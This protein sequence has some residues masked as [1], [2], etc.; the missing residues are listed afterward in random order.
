MSRQN[1]PIQSSPE[2][3]SLAEKRE[4]EK[5]RQSRLKFNLGYSLFAITAAFC[6]TGVGLFWSGK[7]SENEALNTIN[8]VGRIVFSYSLKLLNSKPSEK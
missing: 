8:V 7:I 4:Q 2:V 1:K 3:T 5:L 6:F